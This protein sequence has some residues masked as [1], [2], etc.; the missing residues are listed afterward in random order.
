M[1]D[2]K[3]WSAWEFL[4]ELYGGELPPGAKDGRYDHSEWQP[5]IDALA[6]GTWYA[7]G[8]ASAAAKP[9]ELVAHLWRAGHGLWIDPY[10]NIATNNVYE[11]TE[12]RFFKAGQKTDTSSHLPGVTLSEL[13]GFMNE[14]KKTL[15]EAGETSSAREDETE[16]RKRFKGRSLHRPWFAELREEL[17]FPKEWS[18][19]GQRPKNK[20]GN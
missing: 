11:F 14:R 17:D 16:A 9:T 6:E 3:S 10:T 18:K 15:L 5:A 20:T 4:A 1:A 12:V 7:I 8:R 19:R 13:K 2:R